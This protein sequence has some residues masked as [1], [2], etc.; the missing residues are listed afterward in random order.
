MRKTL[1]PSLVRT[2]IE[3]ANSLDLFLESLLKVQDFVLEF[4][5]QNKSLPA[6]FDLP[7]FCTVLSSMLNEL[8]DR[9]FKVL[10]CV[11][12]LELDHHQLLCKVQIQ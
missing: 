4:V 6:E 8:G 9:L 5:R 2:E 3:N 1:A 10:M 11:V 12:I 7:Y